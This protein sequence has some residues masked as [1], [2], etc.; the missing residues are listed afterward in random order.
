MR[1]LLSVSDKHGIVEFATKLTA[2]G[3]EILST[4]GTAKTLRAAGLT[5]TDVSEVTG[6][7][8]CLDGRVKTL[9]PKIHGGILGIRNNPDHQKQMADLDITPI[10]LLV[11][12]L[13][14]FKNTILKEGVA[15]SDAVENI[16]IG[17]PTMLRSAAK[18]FNDVTVVVDPEDY[19]MVLSELEANGKTSDQ[20]RYNLALKVFE[21]TANYDTMIADYLRKRANG[22]VLQDTITMTFNKVQDLRYGE[23][24]HQKAAFY[25]EVVPVKGALTAAKQLQG[26]ELS[27]NNIND[28]N[29]ALEILKEYGDEPT[30]VAVKHAN[31]C[32]I[33]SDDEIA[34]AYIKAHDSDPVSIFGGI[35]ASNRLIDE[36]AAK[37]MIKTFLEVIVAP[38]FTP[39]ALAVLAAKPNLRLLELSDITYN[40]PSYEVKKVIGGLLVQERD[41]KL[42]NELKVVTKLKPS[43]AEMDELLFAW[44]AVKNTKS[45]AISLTK[46][47][48]LI[49]NGPGQV[50]RVGALENAIRQAGEKVK[51]AV[52]A[53]DAFF[54]FDDSVKAA[55]AAGIIAIIQP[56]GAG[57]DADSIKACDEAG[58]AMVFTGM[59]HFK[60]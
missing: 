21:T 1:A 56:G 57:R 47:K 17:G 32:G 38:G 12:N 28:T 45:N 19:A 55:A 41:T 30:I 25:G 4:G 51:G 37:E 50:N 2:M 43:E 14:P 29:G 15:F 22:E 44:K 49:A 59:R 26:K 35:I 34:V 23:N 7:P 31:P 33:A 3:W 42:Y 54:P 52:M 18:N 48:C 11:I 6:F 13:Y 16:D 8:E 10:D 24:P 36:A 9:H 20:T 53:S 40:E 5:I 58:I 39:E 27:Y 60:H 46:D